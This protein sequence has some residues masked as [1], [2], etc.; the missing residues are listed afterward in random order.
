MVGDIVLSEPIK[1]MHQ[2]HRK[3]FTIPKKQRCYNRRTN[4]KHLHCLKNNSENY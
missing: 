1:P 4:N 3:G 2:I